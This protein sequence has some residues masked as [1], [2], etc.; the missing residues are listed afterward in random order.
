MGAGYLIVDAIRLADLLRMDTV[1]QTVA[2]AKAA[3]EAMARKYGTTVTV[4]AAVGEVAGVVDP[5][6]AKPLPAEPQVVFGWI[7]GGAP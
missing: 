1:A 7:G 5:Q 2:E 4:L 6:W 3:A